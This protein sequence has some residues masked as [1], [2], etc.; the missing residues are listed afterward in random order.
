MSDLTNNLASAW[1]ERRK[2]AAATLMHAVEAPA[3]FKPEFVE[4]TKTALAKARAEVRRWS[5]A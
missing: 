1:N 5:V 4:E 3:L 2:A